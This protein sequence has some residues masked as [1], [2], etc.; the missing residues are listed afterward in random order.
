MTHDEWVKLTP[1]EQRIKVAELCGWKYIEY[2]NDLHPFCAKGNE[3][4]LYGLP[5][6][7]SPG[8]N[9]VFGDQLV[10]DFLNDLNAMAE[11][12]AIMSSEQYQWFVRH[13]YGV[14]IG[15]RIKTDLL[16]TPVVALLVKATAAQRAEAFVITMEEV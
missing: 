16:I 6:H 15:T 7:D 5:Q 12:E 8:S 14:V 10:P 3:E 13:L 4:G 1:E 9:G 11:A 2:R